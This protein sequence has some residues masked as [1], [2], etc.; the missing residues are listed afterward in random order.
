[1]PT[2]TM[3]TTA[4]P[5]VRALVPRAR[6]LVGHRG[7]RPITR[8]VSSASGLGFVNRLTPTTTATQTTSVQK[9]LYMLTAIGLAFS[10]RAMYFDVV[11]VELGRI[12]VLRD[13]DRLDLDARLQHD[14][15]PSTPNLSV[16]VRSRQRPRRAPAPAPASRLPLVVHGRRQCHRSCIALADFAVRRHWSSGPCRC[17]TIT[18]DDRLDP[19]PESR[20]PLSTRTTAPVS[21]DDL[22]LRPVAVGKRVDVAPHAHRDEDGRQEAPEAAGRRARFHSMPRITTPNS[23][24]MKKKIS[25]WRNSRMFEK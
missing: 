17:S 23:G 20:C 18:L 3:P 16:L 8:F 5:E 21:E 1:M 7:V 2:K 11:R 4:G 24:T 10:E 14:R 12:E 15:H 22:R 13:V 19:S 25:T 9:A 6:A